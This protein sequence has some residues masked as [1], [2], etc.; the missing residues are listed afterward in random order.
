MNFEDD[1]LDVFA[2]KPGD[3]LICEGGEPGRAAVWDGR[4][5]HIY[6]QKAIHRVRFFGGITPNYFV[7]VLAADAQSGRLSQYFTGTGIQHFTGRGLARYLFPLPPL[8]EQRRIVAKVDELMALCDRL[9]GAQTER[10]G[11]RDRL[12]R[13]SLT[14]LNQPDDDAARFRDHAR[15]ALDHLSRL[16]TGPEHVAQLR[17]TILN[18]AV[19]GKLV[20]QDPNDEPAAELL[21]RIQAEKT[22]GRASSKSR[23]DAESAGESITFDLP[24]AWE[25]ATLQELIVFGPQNGISPKPTT[26]QDAPKAVTLSATTKGAF[27]PTAWKRVEA[28][29]PT[30]SDLWL[31]DGD[32]LFQRGN[33]REYVG[34][35]AYYSG[36]PN[37]LLYPD[38]MIKVRVSKRIE[39]RYI[40]LATIAPPSRAYFS[41]RAA[42]AQ[43]SM[44]KINHA[45]LNELPIP[46]PPLAEQRRIVA[47]VDELMSVCD[48][49]E[50]QLTAARA[51]RGRLLDAVLHTALHAG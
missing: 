5:P 24:A 40:H 21:K 19:R 32:L 49:L 27:D 15:F 11:R 16:A 26:R 9:E 43:A 34:I 33:T 50:A 30:E 23:G 20:R 12:V 4:E 6:F 18:L 14:R 45:I 39:L 47:R 8:A 7:L 48:R 3:V 28:S 44:P 41:Q 38:L 10:E 46:F 42:G 1:E 2:L 31:R 51:D 17:Q 25:W 29:I 22:Q 35:A 13:A 37:L 36:E